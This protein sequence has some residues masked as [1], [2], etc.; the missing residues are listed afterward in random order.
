[1]L[2]TEQGSPAIFTFNLLEKLRA[3]P[4]NLGGGYLAGPMIWIARA[5]GQEDHYP[6]SR[7][8]LDETGS[9]ASEKNFKFFPE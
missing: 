7:T 1:M 4:D 9:T 6:T 5:G 3:R 2:D 8:C